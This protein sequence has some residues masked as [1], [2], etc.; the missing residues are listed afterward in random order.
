MARLD[1]PDEIHGDG[2]LR[3]PTIAIEEKVVSFVEAPRGTIKNCAVQLP[4]SR[5]ILI[6]EVEAE[7]RGAKATSICIEAASFFTRFRVPTVRLG[8]MLNACLDVWP[9]ARTGQLARCDWHT[10]GTPEQYGHNLEMLAHMLDKLNLIHIIGVA[11]DAWD[12]NKEGLL[13]LNFRVRFAFVPVEA[14]GAAIG[15]P[16]QFF[17]KRY[18]KY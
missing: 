9:G 14:D 8:D 10:L 7:E 17:F 1:E 4:R 11:S 16:N 6:D 3:P 13:W 5:V 15:R 18:W 12:Q 2:V